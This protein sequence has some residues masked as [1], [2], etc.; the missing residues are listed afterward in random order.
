METVPKNNLNT[1]VS[2]DNLV[3]NEYIVIHIHIY[4]VQ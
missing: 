2:I 4:K 1:K 3:S